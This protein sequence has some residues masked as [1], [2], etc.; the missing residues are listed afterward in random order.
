MPCFPN[1]YHIP[2]FTSVLS[3]PDG[4]WRPVETQVANS[5]RITFDGSNFPAGTTVKL[6]LHVGY[7]GGSWIFDGFTGLVT[8]SLRVWDITDQA[9]LAE[10]NQVGPTATNVKEPITIEWTFTMPTDGLHEVML[11]VK[12]DLVAPSGGDVQVVAKEWVVVTP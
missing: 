4:Q 7:D 3:P 6:L 8:A 5:Q 1:E 10:E 12:R 9:V 11:Q 2:A